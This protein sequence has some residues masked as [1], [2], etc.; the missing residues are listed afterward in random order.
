MK[1]PSN[2]RR[3]LKLTTENVKPLE[4]ISNLDKVVGGIA[5][6][7]AFPCFTQNNCPAPA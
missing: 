7:T 2:V 5:G 6:A 4:T 3:P 1:K